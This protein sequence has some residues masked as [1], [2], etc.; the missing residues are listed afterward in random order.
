[1]DEPLTYPLQGNYGV[2]AGPYE[3]ERITVQGLVVAHHTA[4]PSHPLAER[5]LGDWLRAAGVPAVE[6][7]DTRAVTRRSLEAGMIFWMSH[8][9]L[10]CA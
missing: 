7:V 5:S 3:S 2:P 10:R 4:E 6:A 9:R 1:M 8:R